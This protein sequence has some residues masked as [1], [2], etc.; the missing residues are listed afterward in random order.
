TIQYKRVDTTT[1]HRKLSWSSPR[2]TRFRLYLLVIHIRSGR[3]SWIRCPRVP[4]KSGNSG[5]QVAS[6]LLPLEHILPRVSLLT[7]S[8]S[9]RAAFS[10]GLG[11]TNGTSPCSSLPSWAKMC[12]FP[13]PNSL[14]SHELRHFWSMESGDHV[15]EGFSFP[16]PAR[17]FFR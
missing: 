6:R 17:L 8:R 13:L 16:L 5:R 4:V 15:D 14:P 1:W 10:G 3:R 9:R 11:G 2:L 12:V 7:A